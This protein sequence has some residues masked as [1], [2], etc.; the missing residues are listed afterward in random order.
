MNWQAGTRMSSNI[1]QLMFFLSTMTVEQLILCQI[2]RYPKNPPYS[3]S[4]SML[5]A[6]SISTFIYTRVPAS[7]PKDIS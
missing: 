6:L 7:Q 2:V 1:A 3:I 5:N 4:P